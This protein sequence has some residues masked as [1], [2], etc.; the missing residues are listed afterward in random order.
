[1]CED[2]LGV[3]QKE[4]SFTNSKSVY[5]S[6]LLLGI[7]SLMGDVVYEGS[8]GL[9]PD[10]LK[11]L[12]ATALIVGLVGGLGEFLG[13]ALRLV[14]GFLA[15]T[16]HAYWFFIFVG[17]GLIGSIPLLGIAGG[18]EIAIILVLFERLG[19]AM[20]SPARD[21]VL[22]VISKGVGAGKAFG[23]HEFLDQIG[24][25]A[26]PLLVAA[27]MFYS[28]NNYQLTFSFLLLPFLMCLSALVYTF[29]K[30]GSKTIVEQKITGSTSKALGKPFY[31]YTFA[32]M[33]NTIGLIPVALILYKASSILQPQQH[34]MVPLIYLLIQGVD[35]SIALL[36]GYAYDK[37]GIKFLTL[38]FVLSMFPPLFTM[39]DAGLLTLIIASTFF[40]V[41][42]GMQESIYRA[43]VSEFTPVFSRGTAYG[44]FNTV[45]GVGF[46]I[47]G[48]IY[49]A[50][51]DLKTSLIITLPFIIL[52]QTAAIIALLKTHQDL[53]TADLNA[54]HNKM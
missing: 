8:R 20:R 46:L 6:I 25:V 37:F 24:A 44:I 29:N 14:S 15:D 35:A 7:V 28:S 16:T 4:T 9:V 36:S 26:G 18:W 5:I 52:T 43:A 2:E 47:S 48:G 21:T 38:P 33:L 19:K 32:V 22:S 34:W 13:Y 12:G 10:Y 54:N 40:G 49:G 11:F 30:I 39:I 23:I 53:R 17:Y 42:L 51:V 50:L 3:E 41:V 45:Y 31:I 1:M 27:L